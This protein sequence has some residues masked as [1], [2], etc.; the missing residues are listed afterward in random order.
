MRQ[1]FLLIPILVFAICLAPA[2][3]S[4]ARDN[5]GGYTVML[6]FLYRTNDDKIQPYLA[7]VDAARLEQTT[8]DI[9]GFAPRLADQYQVFKSGSDACKLATTKYD[10][11][12]LFRAMD[13]LDEQ[14]SALGYRISKE[15]V[16]VPD[17]DQEY[18]I[19]ATRSGSTNPNVY[20]EVAAHVDSKIN[21]P[22]ASDN[23]SGVAAMLEIAKATSSYPNR[24]TWRFVAF[25]REEDRR[26]GSLYHA[27]Q[28][29]AK[30]ELIKA[31]LV[32]DSIGWSE[33]EDEG[34]N[35]NCLWDNGDPET[36]RISNLFNSVRQNYDMDIE[37]RLCESDGQVSDNV[38]YWSY[39]YPAVL[40]VGGLPY[41]DPNYHACT[42]TMSEI[43]MPNVYN[44]TLE[45]LAV[46]L[47]LDQE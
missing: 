18:N 23:A 16:D 12:N 22:G 32:M 9:V 5:N 35:M 4:A 11:N 47:T 46:L 36:R 34:V 25:V 2:I 19:V 30:G 37:W 7:L 41:S 24:F 3:P 44:T 14:F 33:L 38:S 28:A 45:N 42:D 31:A 21:T 6:P 13:Y 17:G 20:I 39:G 27:Q 29:A 10:V 26:F 8:S 40:S 1:K 15:M 43:N